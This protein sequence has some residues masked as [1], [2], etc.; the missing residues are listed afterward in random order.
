MVEKIAQHKHCRECEKAIL[1]SQKYC[2][3]KCET[4]W[5]TKM[6]SKKR[7]LMYLYI[8]M[9]LLFVIAISLSLMGNA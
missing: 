5:K 2:D 4:A 1:P 6:Q 3:E 9:A 7:Q 8:A